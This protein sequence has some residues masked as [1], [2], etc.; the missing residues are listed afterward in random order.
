MKNHALWPAAAGEIIQC[1]SHAALAASPIVS[2]AQC[3]L[4]AGAKMQLLI[5]SI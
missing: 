1:A 4:Q 5:N 3:E 2:P